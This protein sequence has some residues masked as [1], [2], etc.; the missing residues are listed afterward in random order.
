[1]KPSLPLLPLLLCAATLA[2]GQT[3]PGPNP[4]ASAAQ[5][6]AAEMGAMVAPD[7]AST[8]AVDAPESPAPRK[9]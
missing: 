7:T 9:K 3:K 2:W 6:A 1:M 8:P 4:P 5:A